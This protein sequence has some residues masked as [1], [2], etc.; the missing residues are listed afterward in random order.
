MIRPRTDRDIEAILDIWLQASIKAHDFVPDEFWEAQVDD[1]RTLYIPASETFVF[2]QN[3]D[4]VGFYSLN[5]DRLA[6]IFV[7]PEQ[8]GQGIGKQ[9]LDHAKTQR[10]SLT[11]SV[12]TENETACAFY[13]SQG[14]E[15][16]SEQIDEDTGCPEYT[17][18]SGTA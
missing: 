14:F 5:E 4:V 18:I 11:L 6:A 7:L 12:Y 1:M 2:E 9:L 10:P 3:A 13:L 17:M 16:V 8:Q 15:V